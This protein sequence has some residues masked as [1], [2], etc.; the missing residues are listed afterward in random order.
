MWFLPLLCYIFALVL[1]LTGIQ[2]HISIFKYPAYLV[3]PFTLAVFIP[4]SIT[5]LLPLDYVAHNS[6]L[7]II[8]F[9]LPDKVILYLWKFN[10]WITFLLTWLILPLLQEFF[11]SGYFNKLSKF[12]DAV[13]RNIK[14]QLI[15]LG[16]ST[17]GLVYL[18][19]EVGL[20]LSHLKLMIIALSHI[21]SLVLAL[22]LMAH[23]L[24]SIPRNKWISG[25]LL[26]DLNHHYLKVPKL[27]DNLEDIKITFKEDVLQVLVLTKNFT[28]TSGED[29]RFRDWILQ[30]H[31][32]IPLDIKEFMEQQYTHDDPGNTIS[33]D[34]V[35]T[36]FM[37]KLTANFNLNLNKL[38]SYEAE[39]NSVLKKIVSLEDVLNCSANDNLQQRSR[40]VYR[41]DN[42]LTLLLPK[43]KFMLEYYIR[44][45]INRLL[46]IVLF[47]SS[48]IILESEFFHSTPISLM[49]ILIYSTGINNHNLLQLIVCCITFS[50]MLFASLN[51]LT[52]L[53]IFNMYH[54]V[55]H[56]SDPVSACFYTTYIARLTIPL[57]YN[58]ITLF[59]SRN[60]IFESWFGKS[61]HLTGLFNSMNN[62]I[63]R[64]VLIPVLLTVFNVYDKLKKKMGLTSDMYDS[65][66]V[67]DDD[68]NGEPNGDIENLSNKR[69]DLII[70]EAKRIINRE[71]LKLSQQRS[72]R[73]ESLRPFNLTNAAN[74]NYETNRL[75]FNNSLMEPTNQRVDAS[76]NDDV[77]DNTNDVNGSGIQ[78][79]NIW[80]KLGGVI[81]GIRSNVATTFNQNNARAYRDDPDDP[82]N[83][84]L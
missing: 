45:V 24:I 77:P 42:H 66:A 80:G 56:N 61:I 11:R 38:N 73:P 14:F 21:Y 71:M 29:F 68:E 5:F 58:F 55:P 54:L 31:K 8:W 10:Y 74:L 27:V 51:S 37:T 20:S 3:I 69:K 50:Y 6:P 75:Q 39:F 83:I 46:S 36:H 70:V 59:V 4:L 78:N 40:L 44:P 43:N 2:Y 53:K 34:Q 84:L 25:S 26:Q 30:L 13:K 12:K 48:F 64:F 60:S 15:I 9:D 76:Y 32:K 79:S 49:N 82:D 67:F 1:T 47:V 17:A 19:L 65:W 35:T 16:V 62:W 81:S 7:S 52:R 33:R 23:G 41:I 22:W 63:P 72:S 57:S 18:I 28:S